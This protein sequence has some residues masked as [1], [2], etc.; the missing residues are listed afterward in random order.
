MNLIIEIEIRQRF[1]ITCNKF[2]LN[3]SSKFEQKLIELKKI[4]NFRTDNVLQSPKILK[5]SCYFDLKFYCYGFI[6]EMKLS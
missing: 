3:F 6:G 2:S 1:N 5:M 4:I